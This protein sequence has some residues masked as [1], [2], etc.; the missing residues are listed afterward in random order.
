MPANVLLDNVS[1]NGAGT[2]QRFSGVVGIFCRATSFGG[3]TV[4]VE[5]SEDVNDA[6]EGTWIAAAAFNADSIKNFFLP[7]RYW[8]RGNVSGTTGAS[9]IHLRIT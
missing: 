8:L 6:P 4:S 5:V 3:G 1:T 7:G 9:G 2:P